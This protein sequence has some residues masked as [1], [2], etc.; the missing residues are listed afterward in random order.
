MT[1]D[2]CGRSRSYSLSGNSERSRFVRRSGM[3][4]SLV[5]DGGA[6]RR[7][8]VSQRPGHPRLSRP[9][10]LPF[11]DI[12]GRGG[13]ARPILEGRK[14]DPSDSLATRRESPLLG[15]SVA[16]ALELLPTMLKL[17]RFYVR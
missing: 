11:R 12:P 8:P 10:K 16:G 4:L 7:K 2:K 9:A 5:V 15:L 6:N 17:Y 3:L 14:A 1:C 13:N